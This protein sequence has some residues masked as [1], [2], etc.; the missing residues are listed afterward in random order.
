MGALC[1]IFSAAV[2]I[3]VFNALSPKA[4]RAGLGATRLPQPPSASEPSIA[5]QRLRRLSW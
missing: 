1:S 5:E 4:R 3:A 2:P